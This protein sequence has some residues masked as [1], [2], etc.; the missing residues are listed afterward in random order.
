MSLKIKKV[1]G[2]I[3]PAGAALILAAGMIL[4][5]QAAQA[6]LFTF[7]PLDYDNT[8]NTV[9]P[10]PTDLTNNQTTGFFRDFIWWRINNGQPAVGSADYINRGNSLIACGISACPGPGPITALNFTGP[11]INNTA[12]GGQSYMTVYD[13]TPADG[14]TTKSLFSASAPGGLKI[15]ADVMF[16]PGQHNTSGGVFAL[17]N[18]G[19][20]S[21]ALLAQNTGG[22]NTDVTKLSLVSSSIGAVTILA[23]AN[24]PGLTTF[25]AGEWYRVILDLSVSGDTWTANGSFFDHLTPTDP[26]SALDATPISTLAA[27]GSLTNPGNA[28]DLTDPGEVGL[29]AQGNN[30]GGNG[31]PPPFTVNCTDNV[32]VSITNFEIPNHNA[33]EP[34]S[35]L[36]LGAGLLGLAM[37]RRHRRA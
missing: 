33:A 21:L 23:S 32:G 17:F 20:D 27:T 30:I 12:N 16:Q 14:T 28:L 8:F 19:Q 31:C 15:S 22:N 37:A 26:N 3:M 35:L 34:A 9:G 1:R 29:I 5:P 25:V 11:A 36:L 24:L 10:T 18:E 2:M 6:T 7:A 4:G 13:K